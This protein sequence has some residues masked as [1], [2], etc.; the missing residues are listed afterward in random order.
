[1]NFKKYIAALTIPL[2]LGACATP[3]MGL[4]SEHVAQAT[5]LRGSNSDIQ[6]QVLGVKPASNGWVEYQFRIDNRG[7][8]MVADLRGMLVDQNGNEIQPATDSFMLSK[9]PSI[10]QGIALRSGASIAGMGLALMGIPFAG[11]LLAAGAM[12]HST[13]K[14]DDSM[15]IAVR[16]G[17]TSIMGKAIARN[18]HTTGSFFFP[19]VKP[20]SVK[21]G[22]LRGQTRFWLP[23]DYTQEQ[24]ETNNTDATSPES[25]ANAGSLA[26]AASA[27]ASATVISVA[28]AQRHLAALGYNA[29]PSDGIAGPQTVNAIRRFQANAGLPVTGSIDAATSVA[30]SKK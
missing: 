1:M 5:T 9:V 23:L 28:D 19:D 25:A 13:M 6:V 4:L 18:D 22:Y 20:A 27:F 2:C 11:P 15:N 3:N 21:I 12:A 24:T 10:G 14:T 29:G 7:A 17:R 26:P 30:L 16:F 8:G